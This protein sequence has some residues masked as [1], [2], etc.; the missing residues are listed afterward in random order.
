MRDKTITKRAQHVDASTP[1]THQTKTHDQWLRRDRLLPQSFVSADLV[2]AAKAFV[3]DSV[4]G[5]AQKFKNVR[6]AK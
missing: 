2:D 6:R 4:T 3:V 1:R 5:L